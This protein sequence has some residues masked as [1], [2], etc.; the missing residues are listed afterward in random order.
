MNVTPMGHH[1]RE[2]EWRVA[3]V[4]KRRDYSALASGMQED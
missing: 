3:I 1:P 2:V 4:A